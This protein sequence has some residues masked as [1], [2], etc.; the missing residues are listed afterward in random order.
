MTAVALA[1]LPRGLSLRFLWLLPLRAR[2][3]LEWGALPGL[4][5]CKGGTDPGIDTALE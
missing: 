4:P 1:D 3:S 2:A 5:K